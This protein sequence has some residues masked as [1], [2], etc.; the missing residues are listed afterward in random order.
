MSIF[1]QTLNATWDKDL[2]FIQ[3]DP[4]GASSSSPE[5]KP[6]GRAKKDKAEKPEKAEKSDGLKQTKLTFKKELKKVCS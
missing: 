2:I 5:K 6:K 4:T 3:D 1:T